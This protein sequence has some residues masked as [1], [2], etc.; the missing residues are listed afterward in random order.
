MMS[1]S[2][3]HVGAYGM[4]AVFV[5]VQLMEKCNV[6]GVL[7]PNDEDAADSES[8]NPVSANHL[9]IFGRRAA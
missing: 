8:L 7:V 4:L 6:R 9:M 3:C 5:L 1:P 2:L